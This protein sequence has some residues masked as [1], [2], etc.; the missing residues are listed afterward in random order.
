MGIYTGILFLADLFGIIVNMGIFTWLLNLVTAAVSLH[1]SWRIIAG[2]MDPE[3]NYQA[4]LRLQPL[5]SARKGMAVLQIL[6]M[7]LK[8]YFLQSVF[9]SDIRAWE[10]DSLNCV[11]AARVVL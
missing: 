6:A 9:W 1:L 7:F 10:E 3:E 8:K 2:I 11:F 4:D 5:L